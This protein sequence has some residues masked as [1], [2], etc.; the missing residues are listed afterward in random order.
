LAIIQVFRK[1]NLAIALLCRCNDKSVPEGNPTENTDVDTLF[2]RVRINRD[3]LH[4]AEVMNEVFCNK[5]INLQLGCRGAVKLLQNLC[6]NHRKIIL[7]NAF[8]Y[9]TGPNLFFGVVSVN[10]IYQNVGVDEYFGSRH[11][12]AL[13]STISHLA[14]RRAFDP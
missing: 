4:V 5:R 1:E 11:D 8:H 6:G 9:G 12:A 14:T 10:R 13:P 2:D 3:N 7:Y